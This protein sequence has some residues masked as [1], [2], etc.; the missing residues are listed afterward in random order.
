MT[1]ITHA[2]PA[3]TG[4]GSSLHR[5]HLCAFTGAVLAANLVIAGNY[6]E[7]TGFGSEANQNASDA[8]NRLTTSTTRDSCMYGGC[9][10]QMAVGTRGQGNTSSN[11]GMWRLPEQRRPDERAS[12][13]D[14]NGSC[15]TSHCA[16]T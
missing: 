8:A 13:M 9:A 6:G 16:P 15:H 5:N 10:D 12:V 1:D 14:R 4:C 7:N 2:A 3:T 11:M